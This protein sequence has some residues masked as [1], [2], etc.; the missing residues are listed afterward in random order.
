MHK[1]SRL[2]VEPHKADNSILVELGFYPNSYYSCTS[3]KIRWYTALII[4]IENYYDVYLLI[5]C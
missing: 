2:S 4:Q 3:N 1:L 5:C